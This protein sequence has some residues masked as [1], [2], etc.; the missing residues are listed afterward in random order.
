MGAKILC[1]ELGAGRI[2]FFL[3]FLLLLFISSFFIPLKNIIFDFFLDFCLAIS[4]LV[5]WLKRIFKNQ[6]EW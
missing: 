4:Y 5:L 6:V 3:N 2:P 1:A